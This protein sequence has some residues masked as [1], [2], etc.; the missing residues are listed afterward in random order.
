[1]RFIMEMFLI[2]K[3]HPFTF[4]NKQLLTYFKQRN[5]TIKLAENKGYFQMWIKNF[6]SFT[7]KL[8]FL[9]KS[10]TLLSFVF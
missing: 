4:G 6:N 10:T 2:D 5:W 3:G 1:M 8:C 9:K 7:I